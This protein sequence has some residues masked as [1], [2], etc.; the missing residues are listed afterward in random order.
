M[1]KEVSPIWAKARRRSLSRPL[2]AMTSSL[3]GVLLGLA[4]CDAAVESAGVPSDPALPLPPTRVTRPQ[5]EP[6]KIMS[7]NGQ[8]FRG[9]EVLIKLRGGSATSSM[10]LNADDPTRTGVASVDAALAPFGVSAIRRVYPGATGEMARVL[11]IV[12][13]ADAIALRAALERLDDVEYAEVNLVAKTQAVANDPYFS[14]VG[15]WGQDFRDQWGLEAVRA[16]EAWDLSQGEGVVVAVIDSGLDYEHPDIVDNVYRNPGEVG[17][18]AS[19]GDKATNGIDDDGNGYIDDVLGYDFANQDPDPMDDNGHGT[20][21]SGIIAAVTD[22]G[23][24]IAGVAPRAKIL[25]VKNV[26]S[27]GNGDLDDAAAAIV[28]A[29]QAGAQVINLSQGFDG[30]SQT[31]HD[32]VRYAHDVAGVVVVVAAGNAASDV[33]SWH[34][35]AVEILRWPAAAREVITVSALDQTRALASFSN[36]GT[37]IDVGAPGGG[38]RSDDPNVLSPQ[39]SILSLYARQTA[40]SFTFPEQVVGEHY[41]RVSGTSQAAPVVAGVAALLLARNPNL[42]P[43]QVRQAIRRGAI[44]VGEPGIDVETGY[45]LVDARGALEQPEPLVAHLTGP[46]TILA[47]KSQIQISGSAQGS[48]FRSYQLSWG[49]GEA[50]SSW[51]PIAESFDEVE[52]GILTDWRLDEVPE[53]E[54][55]LR[56]SVTDASGQVYED[57]LLVNVNNVSFSEPEPTFAP[58]AS[59]RGGQV[60]VRGTVMPA[61][62]DHY[63]I[64]IRGARSGEL[65]DPALV[66]AQGG[67]SP[68]LN[69]NL[70][71]LDLSGLSPDRYDLTLKVTLTT[72]D[73]LERTTAFAFDPMLHEATPI[74]L[75]SPS[76]MAQLGL[77]VADID[78]DGAAEMLIYADSGFHVLRHDGS[79]LPGFPYRFPEED[80]DL[81]GGI[82]AGDIDGDGRLEVVGAAPEGP[83]H[84]FREDGSLLPGFPVEGPIRSS[85]VSLADIDGDGVLDVVTVGPDG[86]VVVRGDGRRLEGFEFAAVDPSLGAW[87]MTQAEQTSAGDLDGDG[88]EEIVVM[89][90]RGFVDGDVHE[91]YVFDADGSI[92]PG[93][94]RS[95]LSA[96]LWLPAMPV[97]GDVDGDGDLE[98][99][100]SSQNAI[101]GF[102]DDG[103]SVPGWPQRGEYLVDL[104]S[105]IVG[106]FDGEPGI[107]VFA[108]S[109]MAYDDVDPSIQFNVLSGFSGEGTPLPGWPVLNHGDTWE[110]AAGYFGFGIPMVADIDGDGAV[111]LIAHGDASDDHPFGPLAYHLDGSPVVGWPRPSSGTGANP[112][113]MPAVADLDG[114]GRLELAYLALD[115]KPER[116]GDRQARIYVLDLDAR[117]DARQPWPMIH[118]NARRSGHVELSGDPSAPAPMDIEMGPA[119]DDVADT[120][121]AADAGHAAGT[122]DAEASD[123][124]RAS[125]VPHGGARSNAG[126]GCAVAPGDANRRATSSLLLLALA[127]LGRARRRVGPPTNAP[128][129]AERKAQR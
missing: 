70:A 111:E 65:D 48:G 119:N 110:G 60:H 27:S 42:G 90:H 10:R 78:G 108:G 82:A 19:G 1:W 116:E 76:E 62:F 14:S 99:F 37:K 22:N 64:F 16:Q 26:D 109:D 7:S 15:S 93:W 117:S 74:S 72:G 113:S 89:A 24:G 23:I 44:D 28:Y 31:L 8:R 94:P 120:G 121:N 114:D 80:I 85:P 51:H 45:G 11:H 66:L 125:G 46:V 59:Y 6:G 71:T 40:R 20:H 63:E 4:G 122:G 126:G 55:S 79:E 57:R 69:G 102:D 21:C 92:R 34:D 100:V 33:G 36:Y 35:N 98:V 77:T 123:V 105:P 84:A 9:G 87:V 73:V 112:S 2:C 52:A 97:L 5:V 106:D 50:P 56:L 118:G 61:F 58:T 25:T 3:A 29:A 103:T 43:E 95:D 115:R 81:Q 38:D 88:R 67:R 83:I 86:V 18:D 91:L 41:Y 17:T 39:R 68:V 107:E 30:Y 53:G 124:P 96:S 32:A 49:V 54:I 12:A 75:N 128:A 47:G 127:F 129:Q 104:G 13:D 101:H